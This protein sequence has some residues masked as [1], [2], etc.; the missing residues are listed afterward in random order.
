MFPNI[1]TVKKC[2]PVSKECWAEKVYTLNGV[3]TTDARFMFVATHNGFVTA[4]GYSVYY[5]LHA[6]GT[7]G[8][9]IVDVN[10]PNKAPNTLG[11]DIFPF[12]M[13]WGVAGN[14]MSAEKEG[15]HKLG[16]LPVGL[17]SN[18]FIPTRENLM[19]GTFGDS[20]YPGFKCSRGNG[21]S[22]AGAFCAALLMMDGWD[23]KDD[24]PW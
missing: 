13:H 22:A 23:M 6:P 20:A 4:S 5:W 19:D 8:W 10:G 12:L 11:K 15:T 18:V 3:E 16:L 17:S 14:V 9:F 24:Y 21:G 2:V 1:K 7:G